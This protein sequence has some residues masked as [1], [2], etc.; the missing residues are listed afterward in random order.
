[1]NNKISKTGHEKEELRN[2]IM[3]Q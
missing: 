3:V 2:Q 1:L